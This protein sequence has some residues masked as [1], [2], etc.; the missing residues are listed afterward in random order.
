MIDASCYDILG[1]GFGPSN[2]ALAI[3]LDESG[4]RR[5][6]PWR[7]VFLERQ[8]SFAWHVD[9]LLPGT[10]MQIAFVKDLVTLRD[11]TSPF[12][13]LN[14]LH[15]KGRLTAFLNLKTFNPSRIEFNDYLRW[16]AMRLDGHVCYGETVDHIA[17]VLS[18]GRIVALEAVSRD[19][20]GRK[21]LRR[22]RHLVVATGGR[23]VIPA[24]FDTVA[25]RRVLHSSRY[26]SGIDAAL[27]G[28]AEPRVAVIGG[29]QSGA[30]IAVDL[31]ERFPNACVDLVIR[32]FALRPADD[33]AFANEIFDPE[34]VDLMFELESDRRADVLEEL[35][36]TNYASVDAKLIARLHAIL[37]E[38]C[39]LGIRRRRLLRET[40]PDAIAVVDGAVLLRLHDR[41]HGGFEDA[42]YD[43]VV[44]ATGYERRGLPDMVEPLRPFMQRQDVDRRY[45][46]PLASSAASLQQILAD[47][48]GWSEETHGLSD[49]LLLVISVRA[50]EIVGSIEA[51]DAAAAALAQAVCA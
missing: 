45:R 6:E 19:A 20:T 29:G 9:M 32:N 27:A 51:I 21:C 22:A 25:D 13:F 28:K 8:K 24:P 50:G 2:L 43:A 18:E 1:I 10:D 40:E 38:D 12:S 47:V 15:E 14:Y 46:L 48:Q 23:P 42:R 4:R 41:L 35:R 36:H 7:T 16:A 17:P 5:R 49:T 31:G 30:E 26:L 39:V 34:A 33:T 44:L 11:P 3:A 37:Y